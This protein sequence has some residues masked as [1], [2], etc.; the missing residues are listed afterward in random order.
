MIGYT[1]LGTND[2]ERAL[3]FYDALFSELGAKRMWGD[4]R[5]VMWGK[6]PAAMLAV[7]KPHD[8]KPATAGNGVMVALAVRSVALVENAYQRALALGASDEGAPG[9]RG[10]GF[11]GAYFRDLDANKLCVFCMQTDAS[12]AT[13][14]P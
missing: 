9:P 13:A 12:E 3:A 4:E 7:A 10:G 2:F 6:R 5:L 11:Y 1:T 8:E 14:A